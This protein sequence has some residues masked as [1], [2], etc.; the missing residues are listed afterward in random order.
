MTWINDTELKNFLPIAK[1]Y[2]VHD[3]YVD[4]LSQNFQLFFDIIFNQQKSEVVSLTE[5][6]SWI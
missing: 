5:P 4:L 6:T 2:V 1:D 3:H